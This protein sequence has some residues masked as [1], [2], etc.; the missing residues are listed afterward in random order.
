MAEKERGTVLTVFAV[1]FG[2]L[3]ISNLLKP[4]HL[5]GEQTAFVFLGARTSG[6]A[7]T[8][9]GPL[10]GVFLAIYAYG[11][12]NMKRFAMMM[13]HA[14]ATYVCLNLALWSLRAPPEAQTGTAFAIVYATIAI[15]V[16]VAS[17][18]ILTQRKAELS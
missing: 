9:L 16:S 11:I 15:G 14:Y 2:L 5:G 3:A 18:V 17:A 7:N 10:F 12:W 8:I 13:G 6:I 4:F 1:L